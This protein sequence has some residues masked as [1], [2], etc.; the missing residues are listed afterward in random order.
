MELYP[1]R[2]DSGTYWKIRESYWEDGQ[3]KKRNVLYIG[4][5][6]AVYE[7]FSQPIPDEVELETVSFGPAAALR[8]AFEDLGL[9]ELFTELLDPTETHDFPAWQKIYLL[10]WRRFLQ[11]RSI[12]KAVDRYQQ[13]MF[14]FWWR[15]TV[16]TEQRFY[17]FLGDT[18][19]EETIRAVQEELAQR[20]IDGGQVSE[21]HLDTTD[22]TTFASDDTEY[23]RIGKSKEGIVGRRI[24]GLALAVSEADVPV[25]GE[26]YPGNR[27]DSTVFPDLFEGVC[28]RLIAA[29]ADLEAVTVVFDRGFDDR[30][31]FD[32]AAAHEPGLVAAVKRNRTVIR[33]AMN[34]AE[35]DAFKQAYE[36]TYGTC[37]VADAGRVDIG[38]HTWRLILSY[39]DTTREKRQADLDA[40]RADAEDVLEQQ[41]Q[42]L[43]GGGRGRPPTENSIRRKLKQALGDEF[44]HLE[45]TFDEEA[46]QL[47][48]TWSEA[49][50]RR[51]RYAGIQPI[52]TDH[53]DWTAGR[54]AQTYFDRNDIEDLFHLT[55]QALVVPVQPPYVKEDHLIRAHLFIV[56][57]GLV[58]YQHV[59]RQLPASMTDEEIKAALQRLEMVVALEDESVQCRL[60][61]LDAT[62]T[63]VVEALDLKDYLPS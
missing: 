28:D 16:T 30:E 49:W 56:F 58:C 36:T 17:Q 40:R 53:A 32:L 6:E 57:V 63:T 5:A 50:D 18:I 7:R 9:D 42:R 1:D 14:P 26:A 45:W 35:L 33:E 21:C 2:R 41:R 43:E 27:H 38:E 44:D 31:N 24:V 10:V 46:K 12:R 62:T 55:K 54:V 51:Y 13:E 11:D 52:V 29:G 3:V 20:V 60:S 8:W 25:L 37:Y 19:D 34:A 4:K 48:W 23:L 15:D 22:Y 39:H 61:N 59:K 47:E